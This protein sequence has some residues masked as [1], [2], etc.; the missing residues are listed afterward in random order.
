MTHLSHITILKWVLFCLTITHAPCLQTTIILF[1]FFMMFCS[2][3]CT[4]NDIKD[5][6]SKLFG[7]KHM[8][9]SKIHLSH[10]SSLS[11]T[12]THTYTS[13]I[14]IIPIE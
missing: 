10:S 4:E 1:L 7:L 9:S 2:I 3:A 8:F 12:Y 5:N 13:P 6:A 11:Q 14:Q